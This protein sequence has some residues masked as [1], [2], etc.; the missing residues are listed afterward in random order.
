LDA[1]AQPFRHAQPLVEV[2]GEPRAQV[3][4]LPRQDR[5][6]VELGRPRG[7]PAGTVEVAGGE[8]E[9]RRTLFSARI[10][11]REAALSLRCRQR[12]ERVERE[13]A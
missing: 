5:V 13:L 9:E 4:D 7:V 2:L 6:L 3:E 1:L 8:R 11:A 10:A 12:R